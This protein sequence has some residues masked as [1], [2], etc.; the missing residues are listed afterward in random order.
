MNKFR[1]TRYRAMLLIAAMMVL[2]LTA[3]QMRADTGMCG[4][5]DTIT[6]PFTDTA[7]SI[8]FCTIAQAYFTGLTNGTSA[9]TYS[10]AQSVPRE[11]MAAFI[12]R[13]LDQSLR[14]GSG[15][16]FSQQWWTPAASDALHPVTLGGAD[17]P[18]DIV[19][20][21]QYL[22]TA[23]AGSGTVSRVRASDG[24]LLQTWTE[25]DG[26]RAILAAAGRILIAGGFGLGLPGR[27]YVI[28]PEATLSGSASV[29]NFSIGFNPNQLTFD[30]AN[31]W[32]ACNNDGD[33]GGS[34]WRINPATGAALEF[35]TGFAAPFDILWDGA[36]LWVTDS[37][38]GLLKRVDPA[39]GAVLQ[40][41]AAGSGPR[42]LLFDG[43]NIWVSNFSS[44]SLTVVRA[45]GG[46]RGT[47][48]QTL[49]GN[50]MLA[51]AGMAFDGERVLVC[52]IGGALS[53][54]KGSDLTPLGNVTTSF[55]NLRSACSDG[56][57]FW[58]VRPNQDDIMRF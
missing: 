10:P 23:D 11:Q 12:T 40:S 21:G 25:A 34:V 33:S 14:R 16:A 15:R 20:D 49:T 29:L 58:I 3:R 50:G 39:S 37:G 51:P 4:G 9:T 36:N 44:N 55:I 47:V 24:I 52:N 2:P 8:F 31:L 22:W 17:S 18:R 53:L 57:N 48:L 46:L 56:V 42:N 41:I 54:F 45:V 7:G 6:L 32:I 30:G 13:T 43:T 27:L 1:Q 28:F 38:D 35:T 26:A 5:F 19:F